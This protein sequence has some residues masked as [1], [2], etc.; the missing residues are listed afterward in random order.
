M[1]GK[2]SREQERERERERERELNISSATNYYLIPYFALPSFFCFSFTAWGIRQAAPRTLYP[3]LYHPTTYSNPNLS[4]SL[5][6]SIH[7]LVNSN[8]SCFL[9]SIMAFTEHCFLLGGK[10][11]DMNTRKGSKE[12]LW[13]VGRVYW[14]ILTAWKSIQ[15][16]ERRSEWS[17]CNLAHRWLG[18]GDAYSSCQRMKGR[19]ARSAWILWVFFWNGRIPV[20]T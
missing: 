5:I 10:E 14:K 19:W 6:H 12:N 1:C 7:S 20:G 8:I 17:S 11:T 3:S 13:L 2:R 16:R 9:D 4:Q 15:S 18:F